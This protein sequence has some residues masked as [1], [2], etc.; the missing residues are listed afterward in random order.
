MSAAHELE[1]LAGFKRSRVLV[2]GDLMLDRFVYGIV[3]RLSP[4]AP[5]PVMAIQRTSNMP[6]GAANVARNVAALGARVTLIGVV[7]A[8]EQAGVLAAQLADLPAIQQAPVVDASRPTTTKTRFVADRQQVLRTDVE[9]SAPLSKE[10]MDGLIRNFEAALA[11]IDIVI[12]SDYGKGVLSEEV[13]ARAIRAATS[14]G[15]QVLV[16]PKSRSF[17]KYTGATVLT[18]NKQE[19]QAACGQDCSTDEQVVDG[20]RRILSQG[21]CGTIV[22]TRGKDGMS[23]VSS[24]GVTSHIR[25]DAREVFDVT[26]AGDTAV[27][28]MALGLASGADMETA[29]KLSNIAAGIVVGKYGTATVTVDEILSRID[30]SAASDHSDNR[31]GL[32]AVLLLVA[33]WRMLG[34][35]VA[36]TNGCFDML[37][38]GHLSLLNQARQTADRLVVGL[39]SDASVRKLKG[40]TRPIQNAAARARVL[41]SLRAVDAVVIFDEDTPLNLITAIAPDVLVK[42]ADYSVETVVGADFVLQRGG[43]VVLADLVPS[44][45]T[46]ET[47]RRVVAAAKP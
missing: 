14:S 5:V 33:H 43:Q 6:G 36:F 40:P 25:T 27:A 10:L 3:E 37:H 46:T 47:I 18:P 8:D 1:V 31:Y 32:E 30:D 19:L 28:T 7:G 12:L 35:K 13:L 26:G 45:S 29:A 44:H 4:E 24:S 9:S 21:I 11:D 42:G 23:I 15:K 16:D 20:A 2:M 38:P 39:N 17:Q 34:L 22:V 41:S